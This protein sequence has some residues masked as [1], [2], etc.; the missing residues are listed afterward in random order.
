ML[1]KKLTMNFHGRDDIYLEPL[2]KRLFN[3][4]DLLFVDGSLASPSPPSS[5]S[6]PPPTASTSAAGKIEQIENIFTFLI[7]SVNE[8]L[9]ELLK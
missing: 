7:K 6:S 8:N 1:A 4:A 3:R 2:R 9:V 5:I